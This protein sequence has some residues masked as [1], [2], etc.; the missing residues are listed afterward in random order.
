MED[1]KE[2][3][4]KRNYYETSYKIGY[5]QNHLIMINDEQIGIV[6][7]GEQENGNAQMWLRKNL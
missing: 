1:K 5:K 3:K 6:R 7:T 2:N 4:E